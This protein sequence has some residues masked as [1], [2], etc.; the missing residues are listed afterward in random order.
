MNK[1]ILYKKHEVAECDILLNIVRYFHSNGID[2]KPNIIIERNFPEY[3]N[4]LPTIETIDNIY[5]GIDNIIIH[6]ENIYQ[7]KNIKI[8]SEE[9]TKLNPNYRVTDRPTQRGTK[10]VNLEYI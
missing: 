5:E 9:F 4:M 1:Y 2:I 8:K 3:I 6:L 7:V 10:I